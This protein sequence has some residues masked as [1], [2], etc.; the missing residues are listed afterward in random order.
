MT[1]FDLSNTTVSI[2]LSYTIFWD[3]WRW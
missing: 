2:S 3:I 1:P